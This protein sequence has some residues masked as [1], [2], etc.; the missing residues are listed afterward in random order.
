MTLKLSTGLRNAM[1]SGVGLGG[2]FNRGY[3]KIFSGSQPANA[4]AAETGTL[5][6]TVTA[7]SGSLT[8]ETRATATM[9]ATASTGTVTALTIAGTLPLVEQST[10]I[11][12]QASTTLTAALMCEVL[13]RTGLVEASYSGAVVTVKPRPGIGDAWNGFVLAAGSLFTSGTFA[14]GVDAANALVWTPPVPAGSGVLAKS[15][16]QVWS[17]S[18]AATGTAGW[19]RFYSGDTADSGGAISG[20]PYYP[21][22]D[23]SI[24]T[25]GSDLNLANTSITSGA[26][27]TIDQFQ[28]TVPAS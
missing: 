22:L 4:D 24:G 2:V 13:N 16:T 11:T 18:G 5:L 3:M 25:S 7:S 6:G 27:I 19:F 1:A 26:P 10:D 21:R 14:S 15:S 12:A 8:K 9:T 20:A 28:F 17:F 23:G